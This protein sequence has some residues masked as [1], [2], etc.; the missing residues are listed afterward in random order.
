MPNLKR[1]FAYGLIGSVLIGAALGIAAVL[2]NQWSEFEVRVL[3]TTA[4]LAAAC[5]CGLVCDLARTPRGLNLLPFAGLGLTLLTAAGMLLL[6]WWRLSPGPSEGLVRGI[7]CLSCFT[8]ATVHMSLLSV[9]RLAP[10][11]EWTRWAAYC[12]VYALASLLS[13]VVLDA[14]PHGND[15]LRPIAVLS[16]LA[17]AITL[18]IPLLH[19]ISQTDPNFAALSLHDEHNAAALDAEIDK[20]ERRLT[21]LHKLRNQLE[22][23]ALV[24]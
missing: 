3:L 16:I 20:L 4:V 12:I 11:F 17:V 22:A 14:T 6:V 18:V 9:A 7:A 21:H 15:V 5:I 1:A 8:V 10:R 19:R 23:K 24:A 13:A 2:R